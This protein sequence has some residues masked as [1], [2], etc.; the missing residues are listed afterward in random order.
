MDRD[1]VQYWKEM[2]RN[3]RSEFTFFFSSFTS[4]E[5]RTKDSPQHSTAGRPDGSVLS[6]LK[7]LVQQH[8]VILLDTFPSI[9]PTFKATSRTT[10]T[11]STATT[12][13]QS[14]PAIPYLQGYEGSK[15]AAAAEWAEGMAMQVAPALWPPH[16]ALIPLTTAFDFLLSPYSHDPS[17]AL[18][19]ALLRLLQGDERLA[20]DLMS[21]IEATPSS[22]SSSSLAIRKFKLKKL[23]S[24]TF[25]QET[26]DR[27]S[28]VR[29]SLVSLPLDAEIQPFFVLL[30]AFLEVNSANF[31]VEAFF[32]KQ[33]E[34]AGNSSS[35][36]WDGFNEVGVS[37]LRLIVRFDRTLILPSSTRSRGDSQR[38]SG[39]WT[40]S[41]S[42][43]VRS[44]T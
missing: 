39:N 19:S 4:T 37:S 20:D 7:Q 33:K 42:P 18:K 29:K 3:A 38:L 16:A 11:R 17:I 27:L 6:K 14:F 36:K 34:D 44:L 21:L 30:D 32:E 9:I 12:A 43:Y 24:P 13:V 40:S 31:E 10:A 1:V 15:F 35:K 22:S 5:P 25:F 2:D 41:L 26:A 23:A 8:R 28:Y